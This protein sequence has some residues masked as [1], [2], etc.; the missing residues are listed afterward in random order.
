MIYSH[1]RRF[2]IF[3]LYGWN[4]G[5]LFHLMRHPDITLGII[6][7]GQSKRVHEVKREQC[8]LHF[9]YVCHGWLGE[10]GE[11]PLCCFGTVFSRKG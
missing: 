8:C 7:Q 11:I 1:A 10:A 9:F 6:I 3:P 5:P 4:I 2:F